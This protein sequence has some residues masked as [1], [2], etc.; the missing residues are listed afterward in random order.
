MC[1]FN[2][3]I[4]TGGKPEG[5]LPYRPR[6]AFVVMLRNDGPYPGTIVAVAGGRTRN[7]AAVCEIRWK[8]GDVTIMWNIIWKQFQQF[9]PI[10]QCSS[11]VW[12]VSV[13]HVRARARLL[14]NA[15]LL[16]IGST[17]RRGVLNLYYV[18][19]A[20]CF[21]LS[22]VVACMCGGSRFGF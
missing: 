10:S 19:I 15:C 22:G 2:K 11:D 6:T 14:S 16:F 3:L 4:L 20:F 9:L 8:D 5:W 13:V 21:T 18:C 17:Y 1:R 7:I 12:Q